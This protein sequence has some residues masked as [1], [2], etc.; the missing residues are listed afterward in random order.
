MFCVTYTS[1]TSVKLAP[2][3]CRLYQSPHNPHTNPKRHSNANK[4]N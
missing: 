4:S 2:T 3:V 1:M